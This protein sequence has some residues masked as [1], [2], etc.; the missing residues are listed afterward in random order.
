MR[1]AMASSIPA[2]WPKLASGAC[3]ANSRMADGFTARL[4][5]TKSSRVMRACCSLSSAPVYD[6]LGARNECSGDF[7]GR[8]SKGTGGLV[9]V[10]HFL[11]KCPSSSLNHLAHTRPLPAPTHPHTQDPCFLSLFADPHTHPHTHHPC[12]VLLFA[13]AHPPTQPPT[14]TH[15][16]THTMRIHTHTPI[17]PHPHPHPH[18]HIHTPAVLLR[19]R[20]AASTHSL[21]RS[22]PTYPWQRDAISASTAG[23]SPSSGRSGHSRSA[24]GIEACVC[25]YVC[26]RVRAQKT[27]AISSQSQPVAGYGVRNII[28]QMATKEE[29]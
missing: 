22:A 7:G 29:R 3:I 10:E 6:Q 25:V 24:R 23:P 13:N 16:H 21:C 19:A 14:H 9:F 2:S 20:S 15:A 11:R 4:A 12:F 5:S 27:R 28:F 1:S 26:A 17:H 18:T 8:G